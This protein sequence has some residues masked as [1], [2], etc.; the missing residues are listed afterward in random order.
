MEWG[1]IAFAGAV[2]ENILIKWCISYEK[3]CVRY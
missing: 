2:D 3:Q 1:A